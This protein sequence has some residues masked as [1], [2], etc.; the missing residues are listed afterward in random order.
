MEYKNYGSFDR[1]QA[2][3]PKP[4]ISRN[5][6]G[7]KLLGMCRTSFLFSIYL[8]I[9]V[10]FLFSGAAVFSVLETPLE[11]MAKARLTETIQNFKHNYPN[12]PGATENFILANF[13]LKTSSS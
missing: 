1:S 12:V 13:I 5:Y 4:I 10:M 11:R 8:V 7:N 2:V 3:L 6:E 9:Y